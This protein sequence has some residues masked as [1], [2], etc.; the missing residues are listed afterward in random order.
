M[1]L[2]RKT[3]VDGGIPKISNLIRIV[4]QRI[5][6][7]AIVIIKTKQAFFYSKQ[8]HPFFVNPEGLEPPTN[9]AEICHSIQLNYGSIEGRS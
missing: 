9:R 3:F 5:K 2:D 8:P 1:I 7:V 4:I 6:G